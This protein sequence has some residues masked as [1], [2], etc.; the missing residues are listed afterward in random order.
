MVDSAGDRH[1]HDK[2]CLSVIKLKPVLIFANLL[3][4]TTGIYCCI[5]ISV[6]ESLEKI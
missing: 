5:D 4:K 1:F 3:T 2:L 6:N